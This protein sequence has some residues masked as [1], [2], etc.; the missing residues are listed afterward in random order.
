MVRQAERN[1]HMLEDPAKRPDVGQGGDIQEAVLPLAQEPRGDDGERR[2]LC[3]A[4][5]DLALKFLA[6]V[7]DDLF[8]KS[9]RR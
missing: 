7:D 2:V 9:E 1:A 4:D 5:R 6:A 3:P 8:H